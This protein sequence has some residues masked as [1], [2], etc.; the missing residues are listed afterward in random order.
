MRWVRM[1]ALVVCLT[2]L[3]GPARDGGGPL[4]R[5]VEDPGGEAV[6]IGVQGTVRYRT[7]EV[8]LALLGTVAGDGTLD[9]ASAVLLNLFDDLVVPAVLVRAEP[10]ASGGWLWVGAPVAPFTGKVVVAFDGRTVAGMA[11]VDGRVYQ[12]R[13]NGGPLHVVRELPAATSAELA[14]LLYAPA[15]GSAVEM[16]VYQLTNQER[17][18]RGLYLYAWNDTLAGAARA[19]SQDMGNRGYF[20]H[21]TPEGVTP[22]QRITAAGYTWSACAENIAAGQTSPAEVMQSW[23]NSSDH[24]ANILAT[25]CCD[26]GVGYA[27]VSGSRYTHYW[28]QK[29]AKR[30]GVTTCPPVPANPALSVTPASRNVA[31]S[32]GSTTFSVSNTGGG[33]MAWSAAVTAGGAWL[34]IT[35]GGSG[36]NAGTITVAYDANPG[37]ASRTGTIT[38][39]APGA[40]GSPVSVNVTQAGSAPAENRPPTV[41]LTYRP[42]SPTTADTIVFTATASDPD[43]DPLTYEWYLNGTRQTGVSPT[44]AEVRWANPSVGTHTLLVR[45]SDGRG[46][47]AEASVTV[48][49]RSP[50]APP[51]DGN[52]HTY[53][54]VAGWYLISLPVAG[55]ALP[56]ITMWWWNPASRS[57]VRPTRM[58]PQVGYWA[59]LGASTRLSVTGS[60][61]ASDVTLDLGVAGW[62]MVSAPWTY[63]KSAIRVQWRGDEGTWAEAVA[64]GLVRNAIY[65]Y[66]ATDGAYTS[67]TTLSPWYGYWVEAKVAGVTLRFAYASRVTGLGLLED[68]GEHLLP[69][70]LDA[71]GL[72]PFPPGEAGAGAKLEVANVP[73]PITDVRTTTFRVLGPLASLV[74]EIKVMVFDLSGKLVWQGRALGPELHWHTE[75]LSGRYLANGVYLYQITAQ[76]AGTTVSSGVMKLAIY[77]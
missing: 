36:T 5:A 32:A 74:T 59:R 58:Y 33:T 4:F 76:V 10:G 6:A 66:K 43:G 25:T 50:E 42:A 20:D 69:A 7:V 27:R 28:T 68:A 64:A 12:I 37:A 47:T 23:M 51:G 63:P 30:Q 71:E 8:N 61:P 75:D 14:P 2:G 55:E 60:P 49:V 56:G 57:Y 31:A 17:Q 11:E 15:A 18:A 72:P 45:V 19:H 46:G 34:R 35:A 38:V 77:R 65:G 26:L 22:G 62:H 53:G 1:L 48:T 39:T 44:A 73:N 24:R 3:T 54:N 13:N 52:S 29:F 9:P 40:T 21:N 16:Q 41:S 70:G 67:P